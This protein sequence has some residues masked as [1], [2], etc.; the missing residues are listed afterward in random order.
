VRQAGQLF[1]C[2]RNGYLKP[3]EIITHRIPLDH[4]AEGYQMF[5]A[6][7]DDTIKPLIVAS[8]T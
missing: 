1:E 2:V 5:S 7:P 3:G 6:K 4:I 8:A